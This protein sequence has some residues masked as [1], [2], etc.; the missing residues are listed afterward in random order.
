MK[1]YD[2]KFKISKK[3]ANNFLK[4]NENITKVKI[5]TYDKENIKRCKTLYKS[6]D[7]YLFLSK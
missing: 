1:I 6:K 7:E 5:L 2:R 4:L 3:Y